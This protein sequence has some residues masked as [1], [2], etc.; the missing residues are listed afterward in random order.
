MLT[1]NISLGLA[2]LYWK[3]DRN[4]PFMFA[5]QPGINW[6][7]SDKG[8]LKLAG[9]IY[10]FSRVKGN[11]FTAGGAFGAGTNSQDPVTGAYLN[12]HDAFAVDAEIGFTK[13]YGPVPFFAAFGQYVN[14]QAT[15]LT[16]IPGSNEDD[17]YLIGFK[18]G[19]Q[20]VKTFGQWQA[21]YNYRRLE[22]D[23]WPDFLPDSDFYGGGTNAKG[24]E[25][26]LSLGL[27]KNVLLGF[28]YY[29]SEP[30]ILPAGASDRDE[31]ILQIDLILKW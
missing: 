2:N 24:H 17:G 11:D 12:D 25:L 3:R 9:S 21:K 23:A 16:G 27:Y 18:F 1:S 14:S 10:G 28:D 13:F 6:N 20:K 31:E 8:Y 7:F 19:H 4:D 29:D 5:F 15:G 30:I 22:T 26:E